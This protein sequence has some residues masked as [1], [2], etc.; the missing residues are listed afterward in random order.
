MLDPSKHQV[1]IV[2]DDTAVRNSL[3][4]LLKASGYEVATATNGAEALVLLK[5]EIPAVVLT[6][7]IMPQMSG[8]EFLSVVR[9]Q[10]PRLSLVAMSGQ[11]QTGDE[12]PGGMVADAYYPKG[13]GNPG[14]L[15]RILSEMLRAPAAN[16]GKKSKPRIH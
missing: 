12:V 16:D 14:V 8:F 1:L 7:L 9:R 3:A 15:L 11:Y 2:E 4:L 5:N 13:Y 10:F 6:D